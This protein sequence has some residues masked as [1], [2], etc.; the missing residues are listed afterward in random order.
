MKEYNKI[1]ECK[2]HNK[3]YIKGIAYNKLNNIKNI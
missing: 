1:L 3:K 2:A